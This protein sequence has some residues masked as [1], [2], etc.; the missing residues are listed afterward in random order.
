MEEPPSIVSGMRYSTIS[1]SAAHLG[2][3]ATPKETADVSTTHYFGDALYT[4]SLKQGIDD[5]F[6]APY[7]V[8]R[9]LLDNDITG[10]RPFPGMVDDTGN[11]VERPV[12]T[13]IK[14]VNRSVIFLNA[15]R[16]LQKIIEYL[17]AIGDPYAKPLSLSH[18]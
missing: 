14:D 2:L 3:T 10:W 4:Y 13:E 8:L 11:A 7:K 9:V 17:D 12:S 16:L 1:T 5:G 18:H 15:M 6:L